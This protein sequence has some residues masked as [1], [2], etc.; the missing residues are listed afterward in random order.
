MFSILRLS[1]PALLFGALFL[2]PSAARADVYRLEIKSRSDVL[3][4]RAWGAT[5]GYERM[6]GTVHFA[7]DPNNLSNRIIPN[8]DKAPPQCRGAGG[9]FFRFRHPGA[10]ALTGSGLPAQTSRLIRPSRLRVLPCIS[11]VARLPPVEEAWTLQVSARFEY[12]RRASA[13]R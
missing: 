1:A 2:F 7:V 8:I 3:I 10:H 6:T 12:L 5:G 9:V 11:Y 4:G 13:S